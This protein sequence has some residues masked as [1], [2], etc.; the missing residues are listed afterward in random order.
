MLHVTLTSSTFS[1]YIGSKLKKLTMSTLFE[2]S[3]ISVLYTYGV[4]WLKPASIQ[5]FLIFLSLSVGYLQIENSIGL[6][7]NTS[8]SDS[9]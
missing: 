2:D 1:L 6:S 3:L 9:I 5:R 7:T 4:I 8:P